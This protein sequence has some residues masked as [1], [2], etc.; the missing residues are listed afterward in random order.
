MAGSGH[1]GPGQIVEELTMARHPR[2]LCMI[3]LVTLT[4][5]SP[6][7]P[8]VG[9]DRAL[10]GRQLSPP[11]DLPRQSISYPQCSPQYQKFLKLQI[12]G[13][14]RLKELARTEGNKLCSAIEA[15]DQRALERL[16]DPK[17]LRRFLTER[18]RELLDAL[19]IDLAKVDVARLM[20][21]LGLD[22]AGIDLQQIKEQC[23]QSQGGVD[24]FASDQLARLASE[25]LRCDDWI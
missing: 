18:Q 14:R 4:F 23:R 13:L 3:A 6:L 21:L 24:R 22:A 1:I 12:E 9:A 16:I 17:T 2:A 25:V 10:Q 8:A 19:G 11:F 15:V 20:R 5:A 7:T